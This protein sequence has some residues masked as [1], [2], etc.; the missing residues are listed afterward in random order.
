MNNQN[1]TTAFTV[2]QTP[3]EAFAA[4]NN[5]R[6]WWSGNLEG[7]TD[8]LGDEFTYRHEDIHYSKQ[9]IT[10]L[11]PGKKVV[12]HVLEA[13]LNFVEDKS[14]WTGTDIT[15]EISKKS[16]KTEVRFTHVGLV[17]DRECYGECS[18]AW[19]YYINGCLRNLIATGKGQPDEKE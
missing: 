1:Y 6:G 15:F 18:D 12:W 8:K 19:G 3:E 2:D 9:K 13:N 4:I 10:E 16:D 7:N 14:E 11:I 17:A 5:V